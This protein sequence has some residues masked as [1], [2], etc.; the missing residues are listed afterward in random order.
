MFTIFFKENVSSGSGHLQFTA[1]DGELT[2]G[3]GVINIPNNKKTDV[4]P[5]ES[6]ISKLDKL[7][8]ILGE[9]NNPICLMC[10]ALNLSENSTEALDTN[11]AKKCHCLEPLRRFEGMFCETNRKSI[12]KIVFVY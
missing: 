2:I 4:D 5:K 10:K 1:K 3:T 8:E 11:L 9:E 6:N 7:Q 12:G